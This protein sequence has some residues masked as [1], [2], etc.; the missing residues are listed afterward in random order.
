MAINT[1]P[2]L[3]ALFIERDIF[4]AIRNGELP[5]IQFTVEPETNHLYTVK[6]F[7]IKT[8]V[9][10]PAKAQNGW[11][12]EVWKE[13][14]EA[15]NIKEKIYEIAI[16]LL[17]KENNIFTAFNMR[18]TFDPNILKLQAPPICA[19]MVRRG[20]MSAGALC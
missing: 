11:S 12:Q 10:Y 6:I 8:P 14:D 13:T 7:N 19:A 4:S 5:D 20:H 9:F 1:N 2:L 18:V 3:L 17:E 16:S 15:T